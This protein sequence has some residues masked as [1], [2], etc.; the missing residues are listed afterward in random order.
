VLTIEPVRYTS[1][2][3]SR[4]KYP[5]GFQLESHA[6]IDFDPKRM[7]ARTERIRTPSA[8]HGVSGGGVFRIG[9]WEEIITGTNDGRLVA[10][11]IEFHKRER[12]LVGTR[13]AFP[14]E[15]IRAAFTHLSPKIPSPRYLRLN[16]T[17]T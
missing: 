9:T 8:P 7:V 11:A 16:A 10:I 1:G 5:K 17:N 3:L 13:I 14:L 15:M 4:D 2:P 6:G 12:C